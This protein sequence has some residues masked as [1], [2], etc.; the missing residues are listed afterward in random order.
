MLR[1]PIFVLL[2]VLFTLGEVFAVIIASALLHLHAPTFRV[3]H[4]PVGT[5]ASFGAHL[6]APF[7][8]N[9]NFPTRV[10]AVVYALFEHLAC[11]G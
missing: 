5:G 10:L 11:S 2:D 3:L 8:S 6:L 4:H 1:K 7:R 9:G